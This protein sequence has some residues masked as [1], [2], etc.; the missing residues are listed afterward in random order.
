MEVL[1]DTS[2]KVNFFW[3]FQ[4]QESEAIRYIRYIFEKRF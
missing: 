4:S 1:R 3:E 2:R